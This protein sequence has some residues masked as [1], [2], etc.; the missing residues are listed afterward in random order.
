NSDTLTVLLNAVDWGGH[1]ATPP[2][3]PALH[4]P[5]PSRPQNEPAAS[6]LTASK[7]QAELPLS[8]SF[9]DLQP[10]AM[11][12]L[13][14]ETETG[15]TASPKATF[16]PLRIFAAR[17]AQDVVFEKWMQWSNEVLDVPP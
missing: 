17:L 10:N 8:M 3:R 15:H 6:L 1:A 13:S 11:R 2:R 16:V 5:V 9:T 7:P 4:W 12:F 14:V